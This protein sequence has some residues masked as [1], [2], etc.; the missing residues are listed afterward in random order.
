MNMGVQSGY[1][2][3]AISRLIEAVRVSMHAADKSPIS[4]MW[5]KVV[6]ILLGHHSGI[7]AF[8]APFS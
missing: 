6:A 5:L 7:L 4:R 2:V 8:T 3:N 1:N